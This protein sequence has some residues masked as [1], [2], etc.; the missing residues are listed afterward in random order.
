MLIGFSLTPD[1]VFV[2]RLYPVDLLGVEVEKVL[3]LLARKRAIRG[4]V[5]LIHRVGQ[6]V[7]P[8]YGLSVPNMIL[9]IPTSRRTVKVLSSGTQAVSA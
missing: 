3:L 4:E 8:V 6:R 1:C 2:K 7:E 5:G 9:S